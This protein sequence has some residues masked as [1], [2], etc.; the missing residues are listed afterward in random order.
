MLYLHREVTDPS[1]MH[2]CERYL[3]ELRHY[4]NS[5][6]KWYV[7]VREGDDHTARLRLSQ[8]HA[9]VLILPKD[10]MYFEFQTNG[11]PV[12]TMPITATT[13]APFD[14]HSAATIGVDVVAGAA[15]MR[16]S[17]RVLDGA[18]DLD[19]GSHSLLGRPAQITLVDEPVACWEK[20][21]LL[22][23]S[24]APNHPHTG[25]WLRAF[26]NVSP[27]NQPYSFSV[28]SGS[29]SIW[30]G[31]LNPWMVRDIDF[32]VPFQYG[33]GKAKAKIGYIREGA[34]W[35]R[36]NGIQSVT[37]EVFGT[38][39]FGIYGDAF[40]QF[41]V[42]PLNEIDV[43][44]GYEQNI[45]QL[46]V[47][48]IKPVMPAWVWTNEKK[49]TQW[50]AEDGIS[51]FVD[52]PDVDWKFNHDGTKACAV[53]F[54]RSEAMFDA[55]YFTGVTVSGFPIDEEEFDWYLANRTGVLWKNNAR[56]SPAHSPTNYSVAP[57]VVEV[58]FSI[59]L[60]GA[61]PEDFAVSVTVNEI[62]RPTTS[63][64]FTVLAGYCWHNIKAEDWT[65]ENQHY[66][67]RAGDMVVLDF[68]RY[69][70]AGVAGEYTGLTS[71]S[72][73][74]TN[75]LSLK[76]LSS[77]RSGEL[78]A[79]PAQFV[80]GTGN[81]GTEHIL[82]PAESRPFFNWW[83]LADFDLPTLSF[84]LLV[85]WSYVEERATSVP[86][87]PHPSGTIS[88]PYYIS[89]P[90][91][92][93]YTLN[94]FRET[95]F[96]ETITPLA[97]EQIEARQELSGR[98][99]LDISLPYPWTYLPLNLVDSWAVN[100]GYASVRDCV[101]TGGPDPDV[102]VATLFTGGFD[103]YPA[104]RDIGPFYVT[105]PK[106]SWNA[107][108]RSF[109]YHFAVSERSTFFAH[110]NGT[111]ALHNTE[112]VFNKQGVG[113]TFT[114]LGYFA[115]TF[116]PFRYQALEHVVF[117]RVHFELTS[118]GV[119]KT[120][121]TTFRQLYNSAVGKLDPPNPGLLPVESAD[122]RAT[123]SKNTRDESG[124]ITLFIGAQW[125]DKTGYFYDASY[126]KGD[127]PNPKNS[128]G[129]GLRLLNLYDLFYESPLLT[130]SAV[131][132]S[133]AKVTRFSTCAAV[134]KVPT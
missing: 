21:T 110:P 49:A 103:T 83:W 24:F 79:F 1:L 35:P 40:G 16:Y 133:K 76:N 92:L 50:W 10:S 94:R 32:D 44:D 27:N 20:K 107:Y 26:V 31:S 13:P 43:V 39:K 12:E 6:I 88:L 73:R 62:R 51:S 101:F 126:Q 70:S 114:N 96:P 22:Y 28:A 9:H 128:D 15:G 36:A 46:V 125:G 80:L 74:S 86:S 55:D 41:F 85:D 7:E 34:D 93:V 45:P 3:Q 113:S 84:A 97:R 47:K 14:A 104:G 87:P 17:A 33:E 124:Y 78:R 129:M 2:Y 25:A 89:N 65:I 37:S 105:D 71:V 109:V 23:E 67:A 95:L 90:A 57:G 77:E 112:Y 61:N 11:R 29:E 99:V 130:G 116:T 4:H 58:V 98:A 38:R 122:L 63:E 120:K 53:V 118:G 75:F 48:M 127:I 5:G 60:L 18:K 106:L 117:D 131:D 108:G 42:F 72:A 66:E 81:Y 102:A 134:A 132:F 54:E 59:T 30:R 64:Y 121:D 111:W 68:E 19:A 56:F 91:M 100:A 8:N 82:A 52:W 123:F 115:D 69:Y 119:A